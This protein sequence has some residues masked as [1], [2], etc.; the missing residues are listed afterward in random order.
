[1]ESNFLEDPEPLRRVLE[2]H[3]VIKVVYWKVDNKIW[4]TAR[5]IRKQI[6][7]FSWDCQIHDR[8][9]ESNFWVD[10]EPLRR[11]SEVNPIIKVVYWKVENK[12]WEAALMFSEIVS[13]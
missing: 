11:V 9:T 6:I 12:I 5:H 2:V 1:M 4:E 7:D 13:S 10:P 3:P 8:N